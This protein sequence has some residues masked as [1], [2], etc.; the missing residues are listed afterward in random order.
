MEVDL[1]HAAS[2]RLLG[3]LNGNVWTVETLGIDGTGKRPLGIIRSEGRDVAD[4]LQQPAIIE[5]IDP[6]QR[7]ELDRLEAPPWPAPVNELS[8]VEAVDDL[9]ERVVVRISD[10]AEGGSMPASAKRSV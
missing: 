8:L 2:R 3:L 6:V 10:T 9:G 1:A 7:G 4:R 5:P